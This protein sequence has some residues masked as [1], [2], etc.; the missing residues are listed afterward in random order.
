MGRKCAHI[1]VEKRLKE[2]FGRGQ[3]KDYKPWL[4]VQSFSSRGYANRVLGWKT[5]RDH[6]LMSDLELDFFFIL[7][8]STRVIDIREQFPLLPVE[9]TVAIAQTLGIRH[10]MDTRTKKP[11]VLTTDFL[12]TVQAKPRNSEE[13][14]TIK[15]AAEL[16]SVRTVEKLQIEAH[17]WRARNVDWAIVTDA[18]MPEVMVQNLR[19]LHPCLPTPQIT[20]ALEKA[21]E[22]IERLLRDVLE[23]GLGLAAAAHAC[24][25]T[26]ALEPGTSLSF[27]RHFIASRR[28]IVD[29]N[30]RIDPGL[31]LRILKLPA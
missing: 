25:D 6:H 14:R 12:I 10:P 5:G 31:P 9:E 27:A 20:A 8:W 16:A 7:E 15:P 29:L 1:N 24:D 11:I 22:K 28:W 18:N 3:G 26:L 23:D 17:Y 2:G 21:P 4:V 19:W 13:A 30:Q